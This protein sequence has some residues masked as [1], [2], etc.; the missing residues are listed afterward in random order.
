MN[1][2]DLDEALL[3]NLTTDFAVRECL[4]KNGM[5]SSIVIDIQN[6][7]ITVLCDSNNA[8]RDFLNSNEAMR[9]FKVWNF[10]LIVSNATY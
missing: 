8:M 6:F 1:Q 3:Y 2:K 4:L 7:V 9:L 5:D 10:P